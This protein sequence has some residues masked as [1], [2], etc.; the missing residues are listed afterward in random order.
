MSREYHIVIK[1]DAWNVMKRNGNQ[2]GASHKSKK[3]AVRAG[4]IALRK[5]G[6]GQLVVHGRDGRIRD[7][8]T[9]F[10]SGGD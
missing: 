10:G 3:E 2:I 4:R 9:V 1:G 8:D 5:A 7:S 6:G